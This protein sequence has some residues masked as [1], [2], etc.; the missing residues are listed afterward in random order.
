MNTLTALPLPKLQL[1]LLDLL[2]PARAVTQSQVDALRATDWQALM[3]M[4]RQQRL[5]PLLH[6]QLARAH[7]HLNIPLEVKTDLA[8]TYKKATLR[9]LMLQRE[10]LLLHQILHKANIPYVA[11]KG[12]Y[13]AFHAYPHPALRA[14]RDV[15]IL[16]P[17]DRALEAYQ[18]LLDGGL[19]RISHY[20]GNLEATMSLSNHLPPLRTA[21]G[22]INIELH[23][24]LF[25]YERDGIAQLDP[26][27]MSEFWKRCIQIPLANQAITFQSP[28]DLLQHLIEHAVYHH[29][30]DNGPLLLSDLA[31]LINTQPIDWPLFWE[32]ANN[33]RQTRG[34]MLALKLAQR[35]WAVEGIS[36]PPGYENIDALMD[37]PI[38]AAALL[39][40]REPS[41]RSDISLHNEIGRAEGV[42]AKIHVVL[43][44]VFPPKAKIAANY[45][46]SQ[47]NWRIYLWY[48]AKWHHQ[49]TNRLFGFLRLEQRQNLLPEIKQLADLERWLAV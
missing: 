6:W 3:L 10:I 26:S 45:P 43:R 37:E 23:S 2:A 27:E 14:L 22:Q 28:T 21:S 8:A 40:L 42:A 20:R 29:K 12:S 48:P 36:W 5:A 47:D 13:L 35:Y 18:R 46:V 31:Y 30:F 41:N 39:M 44:K 9:S 24:R 1:L 33:G 25:D 34:C 4:L 19:T 17:K 11:L 15:D 38:N 49:F 32:M 16:V 7:A